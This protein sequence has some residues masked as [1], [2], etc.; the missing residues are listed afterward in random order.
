MIAALVRSLEAQASEFA[1]IPECFCSVKR[2]ARAVWFVVVGHFVEYIEFEFR[3]EQECVGNTGFLHVFF[4]ALAY[5]SGF[6]VER[7]VR[8]FADDP[9]IAD[10]GQ[11]LDLAEIIDGCAREIRDKDHVALLDRSKTVV[12][13]IK[14]DT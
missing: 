10:H 12:A 13:S 14:A 9:D 4:G 3:S 11:S 2:E 6:L 8:V 1:R 5:V 7:N